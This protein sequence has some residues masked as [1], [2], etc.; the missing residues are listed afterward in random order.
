MEASSSNG[1]V[2]DTQR[3]RAQEIKVIIILK[4]TYGAKEGI[5]IVSV[6]I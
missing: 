2:R 6:F 4:L 3:T 1:C 5:M